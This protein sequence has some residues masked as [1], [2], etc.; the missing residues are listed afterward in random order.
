LFD[1]PEEVDRVQARFVRHA[2]LNFRSVEVLR[3]LG[4][5]APQHGKVHGKLAKEIKTTLKR[6]PEGVCLRHAVQGNSIKAY[7]GP[8]FLR[9][10]TT[11][12]YPEHFKVYRTRENDPDGPQDWRRL[13]KGV[14]DMHRRAMVCQA[15]NNRYAEGLAA[16]Q[17]PKPLKEWTDPLC[18]R[19]PARQEP[20]ATADACA[21][22]AVA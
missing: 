7:S 13:R 11:M 10:E 2:L 1:R 22:P 21:Q 6:R 15:A 3:F 19:A 16:I 9:L 4:Q 14:A 12:N 20:P 18:C 5:K 17:D 8:G